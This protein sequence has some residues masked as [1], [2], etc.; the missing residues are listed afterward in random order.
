MQSYL[1]LV[2][3]AECILTLYCQDE[4]TA[5]ET[6][7]ELNKLGFKTDLRRWDAN[8]LEVEYNGIITTL[9]S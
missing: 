3:K 9:N 5:K 4:L 8:S 6:K 7:A 2:V 1:D